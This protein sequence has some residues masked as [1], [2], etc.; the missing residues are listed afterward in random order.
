MSAVPLEGKLSQSDL[1][2]SL[3]PTPLLGVT[4]E[5]MRGT[6]STPH[7][8]VPVH[9]PGPLGPRLMTGRETVISVW[10]GNGRGPG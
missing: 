9:P 1:G 7:L 3:H 6:A 8:R 5:T 2:L 10:V 4:M